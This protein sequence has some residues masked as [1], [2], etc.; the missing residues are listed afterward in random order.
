MSGRLIRPPAKQAP[1][2]RCAWARTRARNRPDFRVL[3]R[4]LTEISLIDD[5]WRLQP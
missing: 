5:E 3:P 4:A 2:D 1:R